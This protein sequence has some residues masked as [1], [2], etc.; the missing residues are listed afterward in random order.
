MI[1]NLAT[2][3]AEQAGNQVQQRR[4]AGARSADDRHM[5]GSA[6]Q[7][8]KPAQD[9]GVTV[10]EPDLAELNFA[11]NI[12]LRT[13]TH[14]R[15]NVRRRIDSLNSNYRLIRRTIVHCGGPR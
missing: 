13:N 12:R 6:D 8:R 4:F 10:S 3:G 2:L 9:R 7:A 5:L 14:R 1:K 15:L 11:A